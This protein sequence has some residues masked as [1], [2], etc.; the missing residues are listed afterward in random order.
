MLPI[1]LLQEREQPAETMSAIH[2][3]LAICQG[4]SMLLFCQHFPCKL[5]LP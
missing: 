1:D 2:A 3:F 5:D 4:T